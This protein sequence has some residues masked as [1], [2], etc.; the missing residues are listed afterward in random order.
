MSSVREQDRNNAKKKFKEALVKG[1]P[2]E[3]RGKVWSH[4]IGNSLKI[5]NKL[6]TMLLEKSKNS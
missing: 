6:Y 4:L 5:T 2:S 3:I 1:I